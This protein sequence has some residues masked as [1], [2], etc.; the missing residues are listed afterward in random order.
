MLFQQINRYRLAIEC[1][2]SQFFHCPSDEYIRQNDVK[3]FAAKKRADEKSS[4]KFDRFD[5]DS[6]HGCFDEDDDDDFMDTSG[7]STSNSVL[8]RK[9]YRFPLKF[10]ISLEMP[11][12]VPIKSRPQQQQQQQRVSVHERLGRRDSVT[13]TG[14][15]TDSI[16]V[17]VKNTVHKNR[18]R[19]FQLKRL[20][21]HNNG[22]I[23]VQHRLQKD[24]VN[25]AIVARNN[26]SV[27]AI[28]SFM[29]SAMKTFGGGDDLGV[30]IQNSDLLATLATRMF[31][32][33]KEESTEKKYNMNVQK[34]I[35]AI[36][37]RYCRFIVILNNLSI[38]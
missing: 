38:N 22:R 17:N 5:R 3:P 20:N 26:F 19:Q 28:N 34:E 8:G 35:S 37:V 33:K 1:I 14:T 21:N 27:N 11:R 15:D 29:E 13:S 24:F 12:L 31:Q 7:T 2:Q 18:N 23:G 36:Q 25:P 16:I 6:G 9:F 30:N 4:T 32:Q 10:L